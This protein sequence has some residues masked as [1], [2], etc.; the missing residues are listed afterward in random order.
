MN[1]N[2]AVANFAKASDGLL[3][4]MGAGF[5]F[6][7][8]GPVSFFAAGLVQCPWS[9]ANQKHVFRV[10]LLDD[11]GRAVPHPANG[12]PIVFEGMLEFGWPPG[13]NPA[14]TTNSPFAIPFGAFEL[15][16]GERYEI[17]V[18]ING[19]TRPDWSATFAIREV[20]AQPLAA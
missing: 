17:R 3:D 4:M 6:I 16:P 14:A 10:E 5:A 2:V 7:G 9:E 1:V 20:P 18:S 19:D 12:E 8:P 15:E 11:H 13:M